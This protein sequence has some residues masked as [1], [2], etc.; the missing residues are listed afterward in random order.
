[1]TKLLTS[2]VTALALFALAAMCGW[3][4]YTLAGILESAP[5]CGVSTS[6]C[7]QE[8]FIATVFACIFTLAFLMGG[9]YMTKRIYEA[10]DDWWEG[11]WLRRYRRHA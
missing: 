9:L 5:R 8:M 3:A 6:I 11:Y 7:S 1:M 2:V 4:A 10:W